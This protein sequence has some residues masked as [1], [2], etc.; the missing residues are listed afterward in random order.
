MT[1]TSAFIIKLAIDSWNLTLQRFNSLVLDSLDNETL[2]LEIAPAR[3]RGIYILGHMVAVHDRMLTLLNFTD[4]L[5]PHLDELFLD[6]PDNKDADFPDISEL[7]L[8]WNEVNKVLS[9]HFNQLS[10]EEWLQKHSAVSAEDFAKEPHRNRLNVLHSRTN[11]LSYH[12]GQLRLL[13]KIDNG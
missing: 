6:K 8:Q 10:V 1:D 11:H 7:K 13:K 4:R 2:F 5:Y 9:T 12:Y 3:N